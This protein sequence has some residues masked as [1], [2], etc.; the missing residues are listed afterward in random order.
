MKLIY[1]FLIVIFYSKKYIQFQGLRICW[2][3]NVKNQCTHP[4]IFFSSEQCKNP[5][6]ER[7]VMWKNQRTSTLIFVNCTSTFQ[8]NL[9]SFS[10]EFLNWKKKNPILTLQGN[11][12]CNI[13]PKCVSIQS[14]LKQTIIFP[15]SQ[16]TLS[17]Y[18]NNTKFTECSQP[19]LGMIWTLMFGKA[20]CV[21]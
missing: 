5:K 20:V 12:S 4:A 21:L 3:V 9:P 10:F 1:Y 15:P 11:T 16:F 8:I 2:S 13:G 18:T 14:T 7:I 19:K 17:W 6:G